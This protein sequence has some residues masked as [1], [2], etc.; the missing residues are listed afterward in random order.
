VAFVR[1]AIPV[2]LNCALVLGVYLADKYTA[3]KKLPSMAKQIIIGLLF[4][5][6][7][8]FASSYGVEWL[9]TTVNVRDA[10]PLSAG[11][12]FGAPAGIISGLIGGLYRWFSVYWGGGMYTRI[13]CSLA[14]ILAGF[15]AAGLRKLMFDDKKPTWSYGVC[16]AVVCEVIHMILI[17]LTNMDN[18]SQAF[19]FVKG[20]TGPMMLGN[21]V[22]V[23]V[24][25]ILVSIFS[26]ERFW[27]RKTSEGIAHTFQR[28]LLSCIVVAYL[29]TSTF[30]LILQNGMAQ[31]ETRELFTVSMND[32][33][34]SVRERSDAELLGIVGNVK[35]EYE[36][37]PTISLTDL[38]AK[39]NV[40]E[41][42]VI[43]NDYKVKSSTEKSNEGYDMNDSE[44]SKEF[45]DVMAE[46]DSFVQQYSPRGRD[47]TVWRKYAAVKLAS[48]GFIQVGYD[49]EQFHEMLDEFV[50]D[51]TKNRHVGTAGFVA[52]LD[53]NLCMVIDDDYAGK[54]IS[55][56]GIEPNEEMLQGKT[57]TALYNAYIVD[58]ISDASMEYM[59]VFKFVEGYCLIAAMPVA[60]AMFMRDASMLTS[61]FMQV[62]IFATLFVFIY[63]LIKRVIINN[64]K[65]INDTLAQITNGDL[66]VT[67]DVRSNEEFA[68][69]SDDIN[70]TVATLKQYIAEAAARIDKEL[71]YAKRIQLSA[72]PTNF[73]DGDDYKIYAQMIAAKEVGGDFYDFYKLSDT[74]V[75]FL[76]A[77]VSGKGI[78]AAMFMMTA[79]TI[80][81]DLAERGLAV[82]DIFTQANE[83][84]C[85]NN[86][87]GM[88]VTA[89][90]GILDLTTGQVKFANAGH[91][92]PLLKRADGS[93]EYLKTRAGFVLAGM[94][95][96]CY[97]AG[98]I[99]L[100][101]GDRLFLYTDGVTEATNT[102]NKLYGEERL[103][104]FMNQNASTE[105]TELL[106]TL[107]ADID[108]FVGE[109]PQ[110]D[111][112]TMLMLDY[113]PKKGGERMTNKTF[114]A[115]TESLNDVLGFVEETL[116]G[117]ECPMKIQTAVCVAIEEV[118]VNIAHYAYP[119]STGDMTLHIGFD[120][121]SRTITFRMTDRGVPFD[122]LKKPDP[123]ITL[124]AEEREIGGLGI[125]IAKKTMD[126]LS[127][128][129]ENG[130]NILTMMKKL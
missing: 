49:A 36:T 28:R 1:L 82:N 26:R 128:A 97:R 54:H 33:E 16:I 125:F 75:A 14:T 61:I 78:P 40:V 3:A 104:S 12:I 23:G 41:I 18:S 47:G 80:I 6:V 38:A 29:I 73:P 90:M 86:E 96:V 43:G 124:S 120:E 71:E 30:T 102:D 11:L 118:F 123:D 89:W 85:E 93:F 4:G 32:V 116:E 52:V 107:K 63:L 79:K 37:D 55:T 7:S 39:Y 24:S 84:L 46:Q 13:A 100:N 62:I 113:K 59:Y 106:P 64:L 111:D 35:A 95:G 76:A 17:F 87:S 109:A 48:G 53:E 98:E 77:D 121:S 34:T 45:V 119:D 105:A 122:P 31:I 114:P 27:R 22:A 112:I 50:I 103:L 72:L 66:S 9:G 57:A 81:K 74:T 2:L 130:E 68:S 10:A 15:M 19:E 58:G 126:S 56:I 67:V 115:K 5:S 42:N 88:F 83:K 65:K 91:N 92:P 94:E 44:Q 117:F 69:L 108:E 99:T 8:A 21:S 70:S 60:E 25:I 110:F 127:Y 51:V 129:Y 101:P 20:A